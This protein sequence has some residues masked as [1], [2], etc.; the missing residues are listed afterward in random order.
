MDCRVKPGK[1]GRRCV[2]IQSEQAPIDPT[3]RSGE[4]SP[5]RAAERRCRASV[6]FATHALIELA[7]DILDAFGGSSERRGDRGLRGLA[8]VG[9][10]HPGVLQGGELLFEPPDALPHLGKLVGD[11][12]R[13]HDGEAGVA[14]FAEFG[15]QVL[16]PRIEIAG[17]VADVILL[18]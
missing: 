15:A 8:T 11:S 14:D 18:A 13:R 4:R 16:D 7:G 9:G 12:Q 3:R 2:S 5:R 1:D 6:D 10:D 17:K